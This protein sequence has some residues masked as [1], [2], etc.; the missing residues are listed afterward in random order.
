MS[1]SEEKVVTGVVQSNDPNYSKSTNEEVISTSTIYLPI[2]QEYFRSGDIE[3]VA[4]SLDELKV[5]NYEEF[6]KKAL[7]TAFEKSAYERELCSRLFS[8]LYNTVLPRSKIQEGFQL[9]LNRLEDEILDSP[10]VVETLSKFIARAVFDEVLSPSFTKNAHVANQL[11]DDT[12]LR[13]DALLAD[14]G[15]GGVAK[16]ESI[17]G[18]GDMV[19]VKRLKKEVDF[20]L[21]EYLNVYDINETSKNFHSLNAPSF[22]FYVVKQALKLT[23]ESITNENKQVVVEKII[24][25]LSHW[26]QTGILSDAQ[27]RKGVE[28]FNANLSDLSLDVP[29]A[30]TYSKELFAQAAEAKLFTFP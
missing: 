3:E 21:K 10:D 2:I 14:W 22:S 18:P 24:K 5:A 8:E 15:R 16:F 19:S 9:T 4:K 12:L 1:Q 26:K 13:A 28:C 25:L 7:I 27:I 6:V 11:A 29:A 20:F 17:W 30:P 23:I